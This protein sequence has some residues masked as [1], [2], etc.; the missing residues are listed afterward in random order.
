MGDEVLPQRVED[1]PENGIAQAIENLI[2]IFA[3]INEVFVPQDRE[4]LRRVGLLDA[5]LLAQ[6]PNGQFMHAQLLDNGNARRVGQR[7]KDARLETSQR[8]QH[9][10]LPAITSIG[11]NAQ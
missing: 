6:L 8:L 9:A 3:C 7:L 11:R 4:M 5:E 1:I 10:I 2:A